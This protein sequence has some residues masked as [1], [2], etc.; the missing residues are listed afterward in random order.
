MSRVAKDGMT[1]RQ[2]AFAREYHLSGNGA[3]SMI[4]AGYSEKTAGVQ[5]VRLLANVSVQAELG[6][7]SAEAV[8]K[9]EITRDRIAAELWGNHELA[10]KGVPIMN[11]HNEPVLRD[12]EPLIKRDI[13]GS[14]KALDQLAKLGGLNVDKVEHTVRNL[15][16]MDDAELKAESDKLEAEITTL[17]AANVTPIDTPKPKLVTSDNETNDIAIKYK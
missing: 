15:D 6:R 13:A 4:K 7:L 9:Y 17:K 12:G 16:S 2:R 5:A 1:S 8:E 3:Q 10:R 11:R 14:N